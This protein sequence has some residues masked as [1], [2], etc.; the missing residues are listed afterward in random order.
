MKAPSLLSVSLLTAI[1]PAS[2]AFL[3]PTLFAISTR[4]HSNVVGIQ[5]DLTFSPPNTAETI[6][7]QLCAEA[8]SKMKRV[9]VPVSSDVSDTGYVGISYI[10]WEGQKKSQQQALC[11]LLLVHGF[12]SSSLEY[13]RLGPQLANLGIDVY[14]VDLLG[15]GYTQLDGV[16]SFSAQAKVDALRGFWQTVGNNAQVVV[17]GASLGGAAVIEFASQNLYY[18][19]NDDKTGFVRGTVL[20]DAQ[21]F[22]DGIGPMSFLPT[23]LAKL[24]IQVLKSTPLRETANQMSYYDPATYATVD[25]LNVGRIHCLRDGWEESMLSFMQSGG[26]RP[27]EKVSQIS[28]PSLVLWGRQDGILDGEEFANKFVEIMPEAELK[29]VEECGHVPHLEKP[30]ETAE[31]IYE[32]L[33]EE[34]VRP[35]R[36]DNG[37]PSVFEGLL[38]LLK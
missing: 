38:S 25:A 23:P 4:L 7:E 20:I 22:V 19:Q 33:K 8:A 10:H 36:K 27:K 34:R 21:G 3:Q 26:F 15:W 1:I 30:V 5:E 35:E 14:C 31:Y 17:G 6:S 12:D 24:G 28:V 37:V 18:P 13:R 29:W 32:F 16:K 2:S 11:P 9:M